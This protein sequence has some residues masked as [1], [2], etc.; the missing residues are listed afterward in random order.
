[1]KKKYI[2]IS[3]LLLTFTLNQSCDLT[4]EEYNKI[5]PDNF[6]KTETDAQLAIAAIYNGLHGIFGNNEASITMINNVAAG[7]MMRGVAGTYWDGLLQH[8]WSEDRGHYSDFLF[9]YYQQITTA[10]IV[11]AEI[12]KMEIPDAIKLPLI[13]EAK[14]LAGW[15]AYLMYDFYGPVPFP[16][17]EM[18]A[19]PKDLVYPAKPSNEEFVQIIIDLFSEKDY[20]KEPDHG[21]FFGRM[22]KGIANLI[23]MKLYMLEAGRT[24]NISFYNQAKILGE[25]IIN[26]G[27]YE[28]ENDYSSIFSVSNQQNQEIIYARPCDYAFNGNGWHAQTLTNNIP[29]PINDGA[30][31][32]AVYKLLWSFYDTFNQ[33][34][35]RLE[36]IIAEYVTYNG[37]LVNRENPLDNRHGLGTGCIAKKYD[38][39]PGQV[40]TISGHDM[41]IYR[42]AD[43]LLSMAEILNELEVSANINAPQ[44]SQTAKDGTN[45]FSDGGTSAFSFINAVRVR[46]GL[47]SLASNLTKEQLRDSILLER[48]HELYAEGTRR[49]DLIRY[50]RITNGQ[51]Y[52]IFDPDPNRFLMPIPASFINEYQGN[53]VQN[54][55]Y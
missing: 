3:L 14:G 9:R 41:I 36:T 31:A 27:W 39:D 49:T 17:D 34:D 4:R 52:K 54:P 18:I 10:R 21:T 42:Y 23:L 25:E 45:L 30:G 37:I 46:A 28:L 55:G 51:G 47:P 13:A 32:W 19:N 2:I 35:L 1:M 20:L 7:D 40:G 24:G 29:S 50:Q 11:A 33:N 5:T 8:Q 16:T 22:N 53:L 38:F 43:V 26:A 12:E 44:V 15:L 6:Y 48:G